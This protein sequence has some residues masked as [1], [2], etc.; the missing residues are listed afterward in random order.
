MDSLMQI[1]SIQIDFRSDVSESVARDCG[2]VCSA[3]QTENDGKSLLTRMS[4]RKYNTAS[5]EHNQSSSHGKRR[6]VAPVLHG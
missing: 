4:S 6:P 3:C 2:N 1:A 5:E